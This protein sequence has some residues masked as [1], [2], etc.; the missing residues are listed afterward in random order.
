MEK[1]RLKPGTKL[2]LI[3][4]SAGSLE[5]LFKLLPNLEK[6]IAFAIVVIVH[7]KND[8]DKTLEQILSLKSSLPVAEVEDKT[9]L[10]PGTIYIAP[11]DYHLLIE[12]T[13]ELSLD[14]SEKVH[15]S[16]PSIDVTFESAAAAY[17]QFA[18]AILLSGANNDGTNGLLKVKESGGFTA[19]QHREEAEMPFM[20]LTAFESG[21]TNL[22]LRESEILELLNTA[23]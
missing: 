7:R 6:T 12:K 13:A 18:A 23:I 14:D 15:Y 16:R 20:P 8:E 1:N 3:G 22:E 4:G 17:G 11:S 21:A 2:V 10:Q 5:V 19:V 9:Q